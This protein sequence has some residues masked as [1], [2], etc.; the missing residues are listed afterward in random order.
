MHVRMAGYRLAC[1]CGAWIDVPWP[2]SATAEILDAQHMHA[3]HMDG[4]IP[5]LV[6]GAEELATHETHL[7]R[8]T[9]TR[10]ARHDRHVVPTSLPVAEGELRHANVDTRS[11]WTSRLF[12]ETLAILFSFWGPMLVVS[13]MRPSTEWMQYLPVAGIASCIL[14]ML[15]ASFAPSYALGGLRRP[16]AEH[17]LEG[18]AAA[19]LFAVVVWFYAAWIHEAM[20]GI[21]SGFAETLTALGPA[22]SFVLIAVIPG[23][24]EEIA[25]RGLIQGRLSALLGQHQ[26]VL[27]TGV[28]F[29]LA[30]GFSVATPIHL[31]I[32]LYLGWL[33]VRSQSLLPGMAC[34]MLYNTLALFLIH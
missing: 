21:D 20:P 19:A 4:D 22:L 1:D 2:E 34:H 8:A 14:V 28:V 32:G 23:I 24:F 15:V 26:G 33:R 29:A 30:H 16:T 11:R 31:G 25:F 9:D 6:E 10:L 3:Q 5:L 18:C 12:L 7:V 27:V 13:L 17:L